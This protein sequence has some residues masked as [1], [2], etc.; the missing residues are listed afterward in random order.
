MPTL[1]PAAAESQGQGLEIMTFFMRCGRAAG[2]RSLADRRFSD[3]FIYQ[4]TAEFF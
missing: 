4:A 2:E 1:R 3:I